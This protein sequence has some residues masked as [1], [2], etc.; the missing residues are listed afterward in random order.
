MESGRTGRIL[1]R[2]TE[3][4]PASTTSQILPTEATADRMGDEIEYVY[5]YTFVTKCGFGDLVQKYLILRR[6][7]D[8]F[9]GENHFEMHIIIRS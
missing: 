1:H 9:H 2:E 7:G 4:F 5:V 8:L 3:A 6:E